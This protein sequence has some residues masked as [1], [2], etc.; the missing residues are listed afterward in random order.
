MNE[1]LASARH[2]ADGLLSH[3]RD[4]YGPVHTPMF[5]HFIDLETLT[6]PRQHT[7]AEWRALMADWEEDKGYLLWGKDRSNLTWAHQS[8]L[9]WDTETIRLLHRLTERTGD[10]SY[11]DAAERYMRYFLGHCV[12]PTTGLFAWGEH[13]AYNVETDRIE[14]QRH[15]L[16]HENPLWEELWRI[17][18][19]AVE[20]EIEALYRYQVVDKDAMI[21]DRH[22]RYWDGLPERDQATIMGYA[23]IYAKAWAFLWRK[24]SD[25]RYLDWAKRQFLAFQAKSGSDGLYPDNWTD[26]DKRE[27]PRQFAPRS[28]LSV[29]ML[30][31]YALTGD[32]A[33]LDDGLRYLR[34]CVRAVEA[35]KTDGRSQPRY[36]DPVF[37]D[38]ASGGIRVTLAALRHTGERC[39]LD[40]ALELGHRLTEIR[41]PNPQMASHEAER[42]EALLELHEATGDAAWLTEAA[43]EG[44]FAVEAFVHPSGLIRGTAIIRRRDYYDAIQGSGRLALALY[45]LGERLEAHQARKHA[46]PIRVIKAPPAAPTIGEPE[47]LAEAANDVPITIRVRIRHP[48]GVR[49]ATLHYA[50]GY[51]VGERVQDDCYTFT[52][53]P[54]GPQFEGK[55]AFAVEAWG[56]GPQPTR[57]ITRWYEVEVVSSETVATSEDGE[58]SASRIGVILGGLKPGSPLTVRARAG[59]PE[60]AEELPRPWKAVTRT[61]SVEAQRNPGARITL[62]Y[63][64][65]HADRVVTETLRPARWT[66]TAWEIPDSATVDRD[67]WCAT[68]P[69]TGPGMWALVGTDRVRWRAGQREACPTAF[70]IDGD[71]KTEVILTQ[72]VNGEVLNHDGTSRFVVPLRMSNRPVQNTSSPVVADVDGDGTL[73]LVFGA[74][75]GHVHAT[76]VAGEEK[77]K[78]EVGGKVRGG[79]VVGMLPG[80]RMMFIGV[81]WHDAG[82]AVVNGDGSVRWQ[83][84][85]APPCDVTPVLCEAMPGGPALIAASGNALVAFRCAD[86]E[87][88]W[89]RRIPDGSPVAPAIGEI[90]KGGPAR[91]VTGDT[92]GRVTVVDLKGHI[93]GSWLVPYT[94]EAYRAVVEVGLADLFGVGRRQVIVTTAG[95]LLLAYETDGTKL[96]EFMTREQEMGI[97]LGV[98]ARLGFGDLAGNGTLNVIACGQDQHVYAINPDGSLNWE[99]RTAFFYT[100]S[101]VVPDLEGNGEWTVITTSPS[102]N[103]TYALRAE[104]RQGPDRGLRKGSRKGS[105]SDPWPTMRGNYARTN[106]AP[107]SSR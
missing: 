81:A 59:A 97:A 33:W 34:A 92:V 49:S 99:F 84:S 18:P 74:T 67:R 28:T 38:G 7:A 105:R 75:S 96:W 29:A 48:Y 30:D 27:E 56:D 41:R 9:L 66:G 3:G 52:I 19:D 35:G 13:V 23:G 69:Y 102:A 11:A 71:G 45:T 15:E 72:Y 64:A 32:L 53:P 85:V 8:N 83:R 54:P 79:I 65:T 106:C 94:H 37:S 22:A 63:A 89:T 58:A 50:V 31:V 82:L 42:I 61:F 25:E 62:P 36:E 80:G 91:I 40:K 55:L 14:G 46:E 44:E 39:W 2:F 24:S 77:W 17:D 100:N 87:E 90:T 12:S 104:N 26:S 78:A 10:R 5:C 86:G 43:K 76:D 70:D 47:F 20:G 6:I 57:S 103:G 16:Q 68:G 101:P 88:L 107:W 98:G 95:G 21:Y 60:L 1:L 73:E 4:H 93:V 51:H